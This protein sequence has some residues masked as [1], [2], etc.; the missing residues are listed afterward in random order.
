MLDKIKR[1]KIS[2]SILVV[3]IL[4]LILICS[5]VLFFEVNEYR[6][7]TKEEVDLYYY[8]TTLRTDFNASVTKDSNDL[9][10]DLKSE[11]VSI[12]STP[13]YFKDNE[14]QMILPYNTEIVYPYKHYPMYKTG[15]Y[16]MVYSKN[17][18]IYINSEA[19]KGRLYDCF[20][21]DGE[22]LYTFIEETTIK[23]DDKMYV[24]SPMSFV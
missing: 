9:I 6:N 22:N 17:G 13:L 15:K 23:V 19:G 4:V 21:Y 18:N 11:N 24:L 8:F 2:P 5:F 12:D 16:S 3:I 7:I 1:Q 20:L 10:I 14:N